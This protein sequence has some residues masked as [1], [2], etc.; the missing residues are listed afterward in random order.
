MA[1]DKQCCGGA[2]ESNVQD[3]LEESVRRKQLCRVHLLSLSDM[4]TC[5]DL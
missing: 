1:D 2:E 3:C 5:S 4:S